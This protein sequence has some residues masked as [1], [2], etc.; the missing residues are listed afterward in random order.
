[1]I[2]PGFS[3]L[4][5]KLRPKHATIISCEGMSLAPGQ[6][7]LPCEV[8]TNYDGRTI[9]LLQNCASGFSDK[10]KI[11][12]SGKTNKAFYYNEK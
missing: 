8:P 6:T 1:M 2:C 4:V 12:V 11:T 3:S 9:V 7:E 5:A 10:H